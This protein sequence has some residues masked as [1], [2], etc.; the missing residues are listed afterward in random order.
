EAFAFDIAQSKSKALW[1]GADVADLAVIPSGS[2][3]ASCWDGRI[4]V[5]SEADLA[6]GL[7][8]AE[9]TRGSPKPSL[10]RISKDGQ[11][12]IAAK[13]DGG[14]HMLDDKGK[15]LWQPDLNTAVK[16]KPK[17]W[18]A[19]ARAE[20]IAKGV[21]QLPGGRVESDLGGQRLIEAPDGLILIEGHAGLSFEREWAAISSVGLDPMKVKYVLATHEH[22]DHAPG[23]YLWRV[24]TG[25]KFVCSEEMAYTL[26]HHV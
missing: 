20:P 24:V 26:Q 9:I 16:R 4:H 13:N 22:G 15:E 12:I 14:V 11:R 3:V 21:L 1:F 5:I 8:V 6:K 19:N 23:A 2:V 7:G 18:V 17:P 10:L 25:A